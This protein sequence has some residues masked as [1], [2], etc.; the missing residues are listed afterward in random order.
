MKDTN[1][2]FLSV[3]RRTRINGSP[4]NGTARFVEY[5]IACQIRLLA[6]TLVEKEIVYKWCVWKRFSQFLL[7][8]KVLMR[9]NFVIF[10]LM[11]DD[12]S[13]CMVD[14]TFTFI[15]FQ[16]TSRINY[17]IFCQT[18]QK[19]LGWLMKSKV[20]PPSRTFVYDKTS[21]EFIEKRRY[22]S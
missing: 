11:M 1:K 9:L 20:F 15:M 4:G 21:L 5:E 6:G 16:L 2:N 13:T 7:L 19:S 10:V 22:L 8:H 18:I 14:K 3:I 17:S 12:Y